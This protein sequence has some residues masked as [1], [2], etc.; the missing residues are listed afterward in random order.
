HLR[1]PFTDQVRAQAAATSIRTYGEALFQQVFQV[2]GQPD[3]Y[4]EYRALATA[5]LNSLRIE[6]TG[7]PAFQGLHWEALRDPKTQQLLA[8]HAT[9]VRKNRLPQLL[10]ATLRSFPTIHLL[11]VT[12]RP[13]GKRDV[14][15]R[16]ISR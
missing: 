11:V 15:Y 5:G 6:I 8:L 4:F 7:S 10:P 2:F 13:G 3:I 1:F 14:G 12:A 16:T 9:L